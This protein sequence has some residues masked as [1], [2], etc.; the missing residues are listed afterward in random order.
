M[1]PADTIVALASTHTPA[2]RAIVRASGNAAIP[3]LA[4]LDPDAPTTH[5]AHT[6]RLAL[7]DELALPAIALVYRAPRSYTAQDAFELLIPGH[8]NLADR[9]LARLLA[10]G[11]A[12]PALDAR[13]A[14]PGEF[15]A[16]A[17]LASRLTPEQAEGVAA[18]IAARSDAQLHAARDLMRGIPGRTYR[19]LTDALADALALVEAGIDFT[20]QEDVVPIT[21][22][23]LRTRLGAIAAEIDALLGAHRGD[24]VRPHHP[25]A[26]LV[27]PPNA[28]K[29]TLFNALLGRP[30]AVVSPIPGTTRDAIA[31]TLYLIDDDMAHPAS[32]ERKATWS[33]RAITL[34]DLAGLDAALASRSPIDAAAHDAALE[35]IRAAD[36][37]ILCDPAGRFDVPPPASLPKVPSIRVRTM[38]DLPTTAPASDALPVSALDAHNLA[39]LRRALADAADDATGRP[40][41][42]PTLIARHRRALESAAGALAEARRIIEPHPDRALPDPEILAGEMRAALDHMG[43]IAG[44]ISP[45]DVIGRIFATFCVGK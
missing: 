31:E 26:V 23:D 3:I 11:A 10:M 25:T 43:Q 39:P 27:G 45:N 41:H 33:D 8:P 21:T 35:H 15:T 1:N 9:L 7:T 38:A 4:A 17:F 32:D 29:S 6:L 16:R 12:D 42:A 37:L 24:E 28:G 19:R 22:H 40:S 13:L 30:R 20:D 2:P 18:L 36:V 5:G 34:I 14:H 44:R